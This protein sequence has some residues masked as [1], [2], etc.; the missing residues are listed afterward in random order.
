MLED[1]LQANIRLSL[2]K[3]TDVVMFRNA[4]GLAETSK[5]HKVKYGLCKGSSDLI[6]FLRGSGRFVCLE[7]KTNSGKESEDQKRFR[8]LVNIGGGFA[9]VVRSVEEA[10]EAVNQAIATAGAWTREVKP[11]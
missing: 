8:M 3:R 9:R 1:E 7:I 4:V 10:N 11:Q 2:G 5:G 6:G